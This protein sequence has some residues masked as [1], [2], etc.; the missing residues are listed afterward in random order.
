VTRDLERRLDLEARRPELARELAREGEIAGPAAVRRAAELVHPANR[1]RIETDADGEAEAATPHAAE[2]DAS[3]APGHDGICDTRRRSEGIARQSE[4][5][6]EDVR[7]AAR[8][9]AE[10]HAVRKTVEHFVDDAV[11][12]EHDH[13]IGVACRELGRMP[14]PLGEQGFHRPGTLEHRRDLAP[15][16]LVHA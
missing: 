15:H 7:A 13:G 16:G 9:H 12:A 6:R 8:Q 1:R 3:R 11:A 10:R 4:R 2:A 5:A 14:A